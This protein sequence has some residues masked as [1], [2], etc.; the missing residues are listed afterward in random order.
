M[1]DSLPTE[2]DLANSGPSEEI[3]DTFLRVMEDSVRLRVCHLPETGPK[4]T[5]K[6]GVLFSGGI[7]SMV[8]AALADRCLPAEEPIDLFNVA[9]ANVQP[10]VDE[11]KNQNQ[12][13]DDNPATASL[14]TKSEKD[15]KKRTK[16]VKG[17]PTP[18]SPFMV[19]DRVTGLAGLEELR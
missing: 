2:A 18:T 15:G 9:F 12:T 5:S 7:D 11:E 13:L 6:L 1:N 14:P 10:D 19:P 17:T 8:M 16:G 4:G 3:V